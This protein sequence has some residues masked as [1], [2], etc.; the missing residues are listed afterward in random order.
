[1]GEV[2][3]KQARKTLRPRVARRIANR[4]WRLAIDPEAQAPW[5]VRRRFK[6]N[7]ASYIAAAQDSLSGVVA[8][9]L[10]FDAKRFRDYLATDDTR[11]AE[12][13]RT[14]DAIAALL[15]GD[16]PRLEA[17]PGGD[18]SA[19]DDGGSQGQQPAATPTDLGPE[20]P[21]DA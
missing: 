19:G 15:R 12:L 9:A 4:S 13:E 1:L 7:L 16:S 3:T 2:A 20:E 5:R 6:A 10:D 11:V 21:A 18:G 14:I 17:V 8:T